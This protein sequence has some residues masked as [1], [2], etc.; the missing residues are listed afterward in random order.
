MTVIFKEML[1]DT[2]ECYVDDLVIESQQRVD[3]QEHLKVVFDKLCIRQTKIN[4]LK[5]AFGVTF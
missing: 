1:G 4:P 2:V 5:C 3:Y